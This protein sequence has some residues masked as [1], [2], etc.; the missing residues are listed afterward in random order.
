MFTYRILRERRK[1]PWIQ[2]VQYTLKWPSRRSNA[3]VVYR[4][5]RNSPRKSLPLTL[6]VDTVSPVLRASQETPKYYYGYETIR[7]ARHLKACLKYLSLQ[8][9]HTDVLRN[10]IFSTEG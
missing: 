10:E 4:T 5:T 1:M 2:D 9:M 3:E 8:C 7:K 6:A